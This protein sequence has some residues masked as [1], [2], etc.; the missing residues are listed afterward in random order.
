MYGQSLKF[1]YD[2]HDIEILMEKE[3]YYP[4]DI[5][6]RVRDILLQQRRTYRYLFR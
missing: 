1:S 6:M 4:K 2:E 3:P 5:K